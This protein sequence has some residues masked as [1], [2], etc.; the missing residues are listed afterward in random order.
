[1]PSRTVWSDSTGVKGA[2]VTVEER[3]VGNNVRLRW[4]KGGEY[5]PSRGYATKSLG[6]SIRDEN[7]R[8]VPAKMKRAIKELNR[9]YDELDLE[10]TKR[11]QPPPKTLRELFDR[12]DRQYA[13]HLKGA[14]RD[15]YRARG[16]AWARVLGMST[17][18]GDVTEDRVLGF[19]DRRS[20]GA[21]DARGRTVP[22][23]EREA[24]G[25]RTVEKDLVFL[26]GVYKW[27]IKQKGWFTENPVAKLEANHKN[28]R[29]N[30]LW[31]REKNPKQ[32]VATEALYQAIRPIAAEHQMEIRWNK[33]RERQ[34]SYLLDLIDIANG[35]GRR[36]TAICGLKHGDVDLTPRD[37]APY[38]TLFWSAEYDKMDNEGVVEID[39]VTREAVQRAIENCPGPKSDSDFLFPRPGSTEE[40]LTK[41][42]ACK[43]YRRAE[44][45]L[46]ERLEQRAQAERRARDIEWKGPYR[47][48]ENLDEVPRVGKA[49]N[50]TWPERRGFHAY[51]RKWVNDRKHLPDVELAE[52]GGWSSPDTVRR[53]YQ[54]SD[55][56]G[57]LAVVLATTD[58]PHPTG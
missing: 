25:P 36:I 29:D 3:S 2:T 16:E 5:D 53:V 50:L 23:S 9:K 58:T 6:F 55:R 10:E 8:K 15:R 32:P 17:D 41:D 31:P 28:K 52:V 40:P 49:P 22:P 46:R 19:L 35:T 42:L 18:P 24:V 38:G 30:P 47:R 27:A 20:S 1:M 11:D 39:P 48:P 7:G 13:K 44:R 34:R 21:I 37:G 54:Q 26:Q 33:S 45:K 12:H 51:R 56:Q 57:R 43:W 4:P 14:T